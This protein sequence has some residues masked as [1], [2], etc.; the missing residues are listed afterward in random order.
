MLFFLEEKSD[1]S[2]VQI[3]EE[4]SHES[5]KDGLNRGPKNR[6]SKARP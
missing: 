6:G 3:E 1:N 4:I 2:N 5:M